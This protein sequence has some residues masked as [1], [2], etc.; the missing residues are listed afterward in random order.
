M[1]ISTWMERSDVGPPGLTPAAEAGLPDVLIDGLPDPLLIVDANGAVQWG[2]TPAERL[3][4]R[5]LEDSVGLS[6]LDLVHPED[7]ELVLRSLD[8]IQGK[9]VGS[10]IE[11]RVSTPQGWKLVELV[12][13]VIDWP[14][15]GSVLLSLRDLT[16]RRRFEV[17]HSRDSQSLTLVQSSPTLTM[18]VDTDGVV[19]SASGALT[20]C[21]GLDPDDV[22]GRP[23]ADVVASEDR[24]LLSM[25][26]ESARHGATSSDPVITTVA[27]M[28]HGSST[29]TPF[30]LAVVNL[31]DDPTVGGFV[32]SGHDVSRRVAAETELQTA[33]RAGDG[34]AGCHRRWHLGDGQFGL[35]LQLQPPV[36]TDV[37]ISGVGPPRT[38]PGGGHQ[39]H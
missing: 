6:G 35:F 37:E 10:M 15:S 39:L 32:V 27:M 36:H 13:K 28:H 22:C 14:D 4:E 17:A 25:A 24:P 18:L 8:S 29:T 19:R 7:L 23:L 34:H 16:D 1:P 30:E 20:R 9:D 3:F 21:L 33:L 12:G 5:S 38:Q 2:N 31:I 11:I 26:L